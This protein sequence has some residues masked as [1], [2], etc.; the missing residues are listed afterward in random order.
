VNAIDTL[1]S[2]AILTFGDGDGPWD[3][4]YDGEWWWW[5]IRPLTFIITFLIIAFIVRFVVFGGFRRFNGPG[6]PRGG[7]NGGGYDRDRTRDA[8]PDV[9]RSQAAANV[10]A[11]VAQTPVAQAPPVEPPRADSPGLQRARDILA[12]RYAR[13]EIDGEEYRGRLDQLG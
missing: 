2:T 6:G 11:P 3:G 8:A 9:Y 10:E 1:M 5:V 4:N 7:G 13:G 12:E